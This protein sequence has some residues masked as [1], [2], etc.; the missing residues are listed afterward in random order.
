MTDHFNFAWQH[1]ET[2][3]FM[4]LGDD[5]GVSPR[6]IEGAKEVIRSNGPSVV[7]CRQAYAVLEDLGEF[8]PE[9]RV[10]LPLEMTGA[11]S[12]NSAIDEL[13]TNCAQFGYSSN[14]F[15][16]IPTELVR[17]IAQRCGRWCW[18]MSP[19]VTGGSLMLAELASRSDI[20]SWYWDSALAL[21][22]Q[23]RH[24][25]AASVLLGR[26]KGRA[27]EFSQELGEESLYPSWAPHKVSIGIKTD[28]LL[29]SELVDYFYPDLLRPI[30]KPDP[31][32]Y[33]PPMLADAMPYQEPCSYV[34]PSDKKFVRPAPAT[35][36]ILEC[37]ERFGLFPSVKWFLIAL[38]IW[39]S[40]ISS[41]V[42]RSLRDKSKAAAPVSWR[43]T[44]ARVLKIITHR[45]IQWSPFR[46]MG[47]WDSPRWT[48]IYLGTASDVA[49]MKWLDLRPK[50][51]QEK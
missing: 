41:A 15:A 29:M 1:V 8:F 31:N 6:F 22:G 38:V 4:L 46:G 47:M 5:D 45:D 17:G 49:S 37:R 25:N 44:I 3:Y 24:S 20:Q 43:P 12:S 18:G 13:R 35:L 23:S 14:M 2:P 28:L 19:D 39:S 16:V 33:V 11:L 32:V 42:G 36:A 48:S 21:S 50:E 30:D 7:R 27:R 10:L 9:G 26:G 51:I 40:R 34:Q